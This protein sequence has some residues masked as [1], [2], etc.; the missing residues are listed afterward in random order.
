MAIAAY[1]ATQ[2]ALAAIAKSNLLFITLTYS[3]PINA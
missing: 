3:V 2:T 1:P